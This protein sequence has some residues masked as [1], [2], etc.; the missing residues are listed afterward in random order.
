MGFEFTTI[1][2]IDTDCIGSSKSNYPTITTYTTAPIL[3]VNHIGGVMGSMFAYSTVDRWL[4]LWS[5]Q[6]KEWFGI[7]CFSTKYTTSWSKSKDGL[8][9]V[10]EFGSYGTI[11]N[12]A[13]LPPPPIK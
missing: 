12:I 3:F 8:Y 6:T 7:C 13:L 5:G 11:T 10:W 9:A 4:K 1:V 2:A